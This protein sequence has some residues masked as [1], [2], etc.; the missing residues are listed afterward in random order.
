MRAELPDARAVLAGLDDAAADA[1]A[2]L[3]CRAVRV[4]WSYTGDPE[5][6]FTAIRRARLGAGRHGG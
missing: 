1:F 6:Q 4:P 3:G 5:E 2:L